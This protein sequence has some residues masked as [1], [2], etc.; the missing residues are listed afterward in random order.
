MFKLLKNLSIGVDYGYNWLPKALTYQGLKFV[1]DLGLLLLQVVRVKDWCLIVVLV[2]FYFLIGEV[3]RD[4]RTY[5][6]RFE[7]VLEDLLIERKVRR[8]VVLVA[9]ST[10]NRHTLV[11]RPGTLREAQ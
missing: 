7:L 9:C 5:G 1:L 8:D 2:Q 3:L 10:L 11:V 6:S 4:G